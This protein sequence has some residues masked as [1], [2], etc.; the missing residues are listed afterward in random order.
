MHVKVSSVQNE[1]M[2]KENDVIN[3]SC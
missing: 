2:Q 3:L 1:I